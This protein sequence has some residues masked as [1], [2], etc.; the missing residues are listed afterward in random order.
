LTTGWHSI[1]VCGTVGSSGLW[2]LYLDG[3]KILDSWVADTGTIPIG[4][5]GLGDT[6]AKTWTADFDQVVVDLMPGDDVPP[7][8]TR[9]SGSASSD[10]PVQLRKVAI[11]CSECPVASG[12][13]GR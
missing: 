7:H 5:V 8:V 3:V 11:G 1:E 4:R 6:T 10:M 12:G 13:M 2:D 9:W